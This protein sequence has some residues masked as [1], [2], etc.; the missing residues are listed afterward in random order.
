[1]SLVSFDGFTDVRAI[2]SDWEEEDSNSP[3]QVT[4]HT[5]DF[6]NHK[7]QDLQGLISSDFEYKELTLKNLTSNKF[8]IIKPALEEALTINSEGGGMTMRGAPSIKILEYSI[9][10]NVT[11]MQRAV[12]EFMC[13]VASTARVEV[14]RLGKAMEGETAPGM[15]DLLRDSARSYWARKQEEEIQREIKR[16]ENAR[17]IKKEDRSG[18]RGWEKSFM[19]GFEGR[20][21]DSSDLSDSEE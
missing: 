1:M 16:R 6:K 19:D 11:K 4:S 5:I 10:E 8:N 15:A 17:K 14:K 13:A 7:K 18:M 3:G 2:A 20:S 12:D 9:D 21:S